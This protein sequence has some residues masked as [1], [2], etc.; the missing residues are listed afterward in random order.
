MLNIANSIDRC[1]YFATALEYIQRGWPVMPLHG[2]INGTCTCGKAE[3]Q[4]PGKHPRTKNGVKDASINEAD[5][6]AWWTKWPDANVGIATGN[7]L[8]VID[9]DDATAIAKLDELAVSH[10]GLPSGPI[11]QTGRGKHL[12]F[13]TGRPL[14]NKAK[15]H[16]VSIDIRGVGGYVVAPPSRHVSG[17]EYK[18]LNGSQSLPLPDLPEWFFKQLDGNA[19]AETNGHVL[20]VRSAPDI[21]QRAIAYLANCPPAISGSAGH[22]QT[23][24]VARAIV[25]GFNLGPEIAYDLLAAHYNPRCVP[26]WTESELRHKCNEANVKPFEKPRGY[27]LDDTT[28]N[29]TPIVAVEADIETLQVPAP[30]QWP[31]LHDDARHGLAGEIIG[32]IEPESEADPVAVLVQLLAAFGNAAGR[33]PHTIADGSRH[34]CNSFSCLV[35]NTSRG[36]KGTAWGRVKQVMAVAD[37]DWLTHRAKSG[38]CSGEGLIH[39]VRDPITKT[40]KSGKII[41]DDEG[42]T[43]KRLFITETEFGQVLRLFKRENNTLPTT[44][45]TAWDGGNLASLQ[46]NSSLY[47]SDTHISVVGHVTQPELVRLL[48]DVEI[49]SGTGNRFL[50]ALVKRSKVLPH[51]GSALDLSPQGIQLGAALVASRSVGRMKRDAAADRLWERFYFE[52]AD[53]DAPGLAGAIIARAEA[54]V[55]RLSMIYALID[56]ASIIDEQHLAAAIAVWRYCA[57]SAAIIFGKV[58]IDPLKQKVLELLQAAPHGMTRTDLHAATGRN[59]KAAELLRVLADLR[60]AGKAV[61]DTDP[62]GQRG[63]PSERWQAVTP[64]KETKETKEMPEAGIT[65]FNSFLSSPSKAESEE[66]IEV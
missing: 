51:G 30:P 18:W 7:H 8:A 4:S 41:V 43:D 56:G 29:T 62:T 14:G 23:F 5:I 12:Y 61:A 36:R 6:R 40:D 27:L 57:E 9:L 53:A 26:S 2:V 63:R 1:E 49:F 52:S 45:R 59:C 39:H 10:G 38:L 34:G 19:P 64:T 47:A 24:D 32:I 65:S 15:V 33:G 58:A 31:T 42:V 21:I 55:L 35:G 54:Q 13:R 37:S 60:D 16:G 28:T 48:S 46:R 3:C 50:W 25:Y 11:V 44:L 66:V 17:A 20:T 22:N